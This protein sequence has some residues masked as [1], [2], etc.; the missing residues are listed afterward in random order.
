[1]TV[2]RRGN[3]GGG[4]STTSKLGREGVSAQKAGA[5]TP[6]LNLPEGHAI[7]TVCVTIRVIVI[8]RLNPCHQ[9]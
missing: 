7:G 4:Q 1:M 8:T 3:N 2:Y 9:G 6:F 5:H